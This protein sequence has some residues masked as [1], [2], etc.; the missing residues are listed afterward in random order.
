VSTGFFSLSDGSFRSNRYVKD[1]SDLTL[2]LRLKDN[3]VYF[4]EVSGRAGRGRFVATGDVGVEG[5]RV[6][7]YNVAIRTLGRRGIPVEV[8]QLSVPPG[9]LLTR[10]SVLRRTLEAASQ[11]RPRLDLTIK[12]PHG[13]HVVAG[14]IVLDD[15]HF[16]YPPSKDAFKGGTRGSWWYEFWHDAIWDVALKTGKDTWYR[17]EYV[18]AHVDGK[19]SIQG[20]KDTLRVGGKISADQGAVNYLSQSFQIRRALFE[21]VTD[22]RPGV[23]DGGSLAYLSGEAEKSATT[24][25]NRGVASL[26]VITMVIPR[27][28]L[29]EIKPR[30][31]SRNNPGLTSER[32]FQKMLG[33][34]AADPLQSPTP[35]EQDQLLRAGLVQLVGSSAAPFANRLAQLFGIDMI[36]AIYDPTTTPSGEAVRLPDSGLGPRPAEVGT[37]HAALTRWQ[38][39]LRGTGVSA[40]VRLTDRLFGL[41]KFKVDQTTENQVFLRD[42]VQVVGRVLGSLYVTFSSELDG[43]SVLG[44][45]PNRQAMLEQQW[46]F[47]LPKPKKAPE[48]SETAR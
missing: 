42:E 5:F 28:P 46:R 2:N 44:Q 21:V 34:S 4:D 20:P 41:Y 15:T 24:L 29:G 12:G 17:N 32:V 10:F 43:H 13:S 18:N 22:T 25:D 48:K 3:R 30:F 37:G 31:L 40:G 16:T 38:D 8:P 45:P 11:G 26:D 33:F 19:I 14:E 6:K 47:G 9:P 39:L 7:D 1:V 23:S 35:E 27:A 36:S